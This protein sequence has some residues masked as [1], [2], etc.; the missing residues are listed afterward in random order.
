MYGDEIEPPLYE[1]IWN[2]LLEEFPHILPRVRCHFGF[3][4]KYLEAA[5]DEPKKIASASPWAKEVWNGRGT[6]VGG[7]GTELNGMT[8]QL[9][10]AG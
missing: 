10:G 9:G 3:G 8:A 4:P 1:D 2:I 5:G 7:G 6:L